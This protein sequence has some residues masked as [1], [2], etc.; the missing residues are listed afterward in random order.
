MV[1]SVL[2][3]IHS[4]LPRLPRVSSA[5]MVVVA[6]VVPLVVVAVE[7]VV[8][9]MSEQVGD[10]YEVLKALVFGMTRL[11]VSLAL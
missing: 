8:E 10:G 11:L 9:G 5:V 2:Q 3:M 7:V 6:G 4:P 1:L